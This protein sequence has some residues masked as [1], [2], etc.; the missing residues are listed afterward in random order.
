MS[1]TPDT[2]YPLFREVPFM[3]GIFFSVGAVHQDQGSPLRRL[4]EGAFIH[5]TCHASNPASGA[6]A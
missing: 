6:G 1:F 2:F 5:P 4:K 3:P